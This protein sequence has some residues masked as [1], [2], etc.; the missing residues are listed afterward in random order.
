MGA[1]MLA[2]LPS[3]MERGIV[4]IL[5]AHVTF[6]LAVVVR[7]VGAVWQHLPEDMEAAAATLGASPARVA[8]EITIPLLRPALVAA[9][10][11]VFVSRSRRTGSFGCSAMPARRRSRSRSGGGP[12][13]WAMS[14]APQSWPLLSS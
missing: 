11:I 2:V 7:T 6:N 13:S 10:A 5:A 1:A 12:H 9:G 8:W 14:L 4:A 3:S